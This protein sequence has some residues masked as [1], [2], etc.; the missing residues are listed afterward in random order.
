[1][2]K[3]QAN[4]RPEG[5]AALVTAMS[6]R[7][8]AGEKSFE[9]GKAYFAS[10]AV[11]SLVDSGETVKARV[12]GTDEY[13]VTLRAN[14]R[15]LDWDCS[16]PLG[17]EGTFCKHAV[18]T[19]LAWI[20]SGKHGA[21]GPGYTGRGE[22]DAIRAHLAGLDRE[23]LVELLMKQVEEDELLRSRLRV[24]AVR[25]SADPKALKD[26]VRKALHTGGFV[27][28]RGMRAFVQR[29][30]SVED[31]VQGLLKDGQ[32]ALAAQIAEYAMQRGLTAYERVD[33]SAGSFG[34][35]LR[36]IAALHLDACRAARLDGAALG[37]T[38]FEFK[39][40]D[41]WGFFAWQDYA[42]LL[43]EAGRAA[44]RAAAEKEWAKVPARAPG[45]GGR[46]DS[47]HFQITSIMEE[48]A[49]E[50]GDIDALVAVKSRDLASAYSFLKVAEI[51]ANAGRR[52]E[53]LAWAER[54]RA[55]F[56]Q[57]ADLRLV[58]FLVKEYGAR[59]RCDDAAR[60]AWEAY[61][62]D[63]DRRGFARLKRAAK[64]TKDPAA[65]REKA[66]AWAREGRA[67]S[68]AKRPVWRSAGHILLIELHLEDGDSDAA[69]ALANEH[70]CPEHLWTE[71]ARAR[72]KK[73]P[74]HAAAIYRSFVD[75]VVG[76]AN[77]SAYDSGVDLILDVRELMRRA[78][79]TREFAAWGEAQG[80]EELRQAPG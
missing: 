55:A 21:T 47:E 40:R 27:E 79:E 13:T 34:D 42:P 3:A 25:G 24:R 4:A 44:Y 63:P 6:L 37:K 51:L 1:M 57:G 10:G 75:H 48:L 76:R 65:W 11:A 43:G 39:L 30:A 32:A 60:L 77:N 19:G 26:T 12:I 28:Y 22:F 74:A 73:H 9:R 70:G 64:D 67:G 78:G 17:E 36:R 50:A 33:D 61:A 52:D 62:G 41:Q 80:E 16:C 49:S 31:L 14:G 71:I 18:A 45:E 53:A 58:E 7:A 56:A 8:L 15:A 23:A 46:F 69:L 29:A 72:E 68:A 5:F 35:L 38:L 20:A 54:G 66:F 59:K 2:G